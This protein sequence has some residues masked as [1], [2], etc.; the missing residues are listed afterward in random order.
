MISA[1]RRPLGPSLT[2]LL[3]EE[4]ANHKG[5]DPDDPGFC[6]YEDTDPEALEL[7]LEGTEGP[8]TT[9]FR[10]AGVDV[11]VEKTD[12]GDISVDVESAVQ[13]R[14]TSD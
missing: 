8:M 12:A 13:Q 9:R 5:V 11:T 2:S 3:V 1:Q 6:L 7:L 14:P 10:I 4:I